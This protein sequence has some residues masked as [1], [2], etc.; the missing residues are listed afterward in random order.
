MASFAAYSS[1]SPSSSSSDFSQPNFSMV[2]PP[3]H[4]FL[5]PITLKLTDD[6]F[7]LIWKQQIFATLC[8]LNLMHLLDGNSVSSQF[9]QTANR[10]PTTNPAYLHHH[11]QDKLL[12]AWLFA[13]MSSSILTKMV[14]LESSY[15]I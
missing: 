1:S 14:G 10:E 13:S 15:A 7:F 11:K 8:G 3:L 5:T 6:F 9:L 2:A 12:V 4:H